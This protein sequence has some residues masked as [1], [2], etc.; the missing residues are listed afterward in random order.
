MAVEVKPDK[1]L[2]PSREEIERWKLVD[3]ANQLF[4]GLRRALS[5]IPEFASQAGLSSFWEN[6]EVEFQIGNDKYSVRHDHKR[7]IN[8]GE[9]TQEGLRIMHSQEQKVNG[10]RRTK[11]EDIWIL[12][13]D[14]RSS[15]GGDYSSLNIS[16]H[17]HITVDDGSRFGKDTDHIGETRSEAAIQYIKDFT[18]N[19][20]SA[21]SSPQAT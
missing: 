21:H 18:E 10:K 1:K 4:S 17:S 6:N 15:G 20:K 5:S 12:K 16:Y 11:S 7:P 3:P 8:S 19:L 13:V 2:F 9:Q 14:R